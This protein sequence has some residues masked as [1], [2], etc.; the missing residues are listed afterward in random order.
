MENR[1]SFLNLAIPDTSINQAPKGDII[2]DFGLTR[3]SLMISEYLEGFIKHSHL[4]ISL[5]E[6]SNLN[7]HIVRALVVLSQIKGVVMTF[8]L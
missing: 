3:L 5:D 1:L 8:Y 7:G 6:N 2:V 4:A